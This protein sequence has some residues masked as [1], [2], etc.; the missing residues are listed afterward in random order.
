VPGHA[1]ENVTELYVNVQNDEALRQTSAEK[2]GLGFQLKSLYLFPS[3]PQF[4]GMENQ[5]QML[6][7]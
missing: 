6:V 7:V 5:Q 1:P 3:V 2:A 4:S